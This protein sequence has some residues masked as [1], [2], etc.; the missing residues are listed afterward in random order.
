[1]KTLIIAEAGINH[2]GNFKLAKK[3]IY[4]AAISGA[5]LIKFQ[6]YKTSEM[7]VMRAK[8]ADYQIKNLNKKH[9]QYQ[10][11]EKYVLKNQFY[12]ELI[13]FAKKMGIGF[14]SSPFDNES[15][16]FLVKLKLPFI[17]VPSGEINNYPYLKLLGKYNKKI[18]LSTGMS[19]LSEVSNAI[20]V[21]VRNGTSKKNISLLHCHT[22]Y[23]S[24]PKNLNLRS[25]TSLKKNII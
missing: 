6:T 20:R 14:I 8:A 12:P 1:M 5:D 15:I 19:T 11:L 4:M 21:L 22:D 2:N 3:L 16:K 9:S 23:P 10:I 7:I 13:K 17:K 25:I 24:S 18:I